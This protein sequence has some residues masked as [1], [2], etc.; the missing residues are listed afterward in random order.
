MNQRLRFP[1]ALA[2]GAGL[3][4]GSTTFANEGALRPGSN[5][6]GAAPQSF[7]WSDFDGD[8]RADVFVV[9]P[10]SGGH[11]LRNAG[12]GEFVDVTL[13]TGLVG[14]TDEAFMA[15]WGD[16]DEDGRTDVFLAS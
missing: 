14:L 8:G 10:G 3:L 12:G 2:L 15:A 11:L 4:A 13:E 5:E 16:Y 6:P 1:Q 7:F 9:V